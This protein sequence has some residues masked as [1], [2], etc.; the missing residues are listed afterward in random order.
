MPGRRPGAH[1]L[2]T[3]TQGGPSVVQRLLALF[4]MMP[5]QWHVKPVPSVDAYTELN[6]CVKC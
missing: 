1:I 3:S 2:S 4:K 5:K 6:S